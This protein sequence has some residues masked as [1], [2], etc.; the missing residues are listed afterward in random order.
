MPPFDDAAGFPFPFWSDFPLV[1]LLV[2]V[3]PLLDFPLSSAGFLPKPNSLCASDLF[4]VLSDAPDFPEVPD[5][6]EEPDFPE[7]PDFADCNK[8]INA[9]SG[10]KL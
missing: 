4:P 2:S 7:V 8:P 1:V 6:P 10:E 5:L 9:Y 3:L